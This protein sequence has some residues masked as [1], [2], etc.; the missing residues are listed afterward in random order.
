MIEKLYYWLR[1]KISKPDER[2]EPSSGHWQHTIRDFAF[3]LCNSDQG[4]ILEVGCG[5]GLFLQKFVRKFTAAKLFGL[6]ISLEQL[7][8][9]KKR[10]KERVHLFRAD[11][12]SLPFQEDYFDSIVCI[13]VFMN[14]PR[15]EMFIQSFQEMKRVCKKGG[16]IIFDMRNR[17]NPLVY[18]KYKLVKYYDSTIDSN[19]LRM[20]TLK[21]IEVKLNSLGL[22]INKKT[23]IGLPPGMFA[24]IVMVE[25]VNK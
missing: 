18:M 23:T 9:A 21:S 12:G 1:R 10:G 13:N 8:K 2:G 3:K 14:M 5:E 22:M 19:S 7:R 20:H 25:V 15:D 24:P 11:A 17:L 6:D 16:R 4:N